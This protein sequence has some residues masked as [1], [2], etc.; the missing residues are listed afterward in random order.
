M[1][2]TSGKLTLAAFMLITASPGPGIGDATSSMTSES[3]GPYDLHSTAF[4]VAEFA[5]KSRKHERDQLT[6]GLAGGDGN[7]LPGDVTRA[8]AAEKRGERGDVL[9]GRHALQRRTLDE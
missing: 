9:R 1:I 8:V 6:C 3:G 4:M 5:T 7:A 2:R